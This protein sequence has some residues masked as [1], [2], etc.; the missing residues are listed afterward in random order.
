MRFVKTNGVN[1]ACADE[2]SGSPAF[3][4]VHGLAC[5]RTFWQPQ[6]DDLKRDHRCV[7][8]DLRG[9]GESPVAF[10]CDPETAAADVAGVIEVLDLGP[11]IIVGHSLGGVVALLLNYA[12]PELV[13]GVVAGDTPMG[14]ELGANMGRLAAAVRAEGS[15]KPIER[16]V[17]S[18][19][20]EST[21]EAVRDNVRKVMLG[22]PP[23][24][25]AGMLDGCA[26]LPAI[27]TDL[28][29]AADRKPFMA[30]W[31]ER[32]LGDPAWLRDT[33]MFLRQEPL[34]ATGHFFQLEEPAMTTALLRAFLDDVERDPRV[35]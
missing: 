21:P 4:F 20:V 22:C 27:S 11:S 30:I 32:P 31:A 7:A 35:V 10:P 33:T 19:F 15:T 8:V 2:G 12:R 6:F 24:V 16:L 3:F 23:D 5:D 34:A 14:A 28:V 13:L 1:L 17:E 18:F 26:R 9:R 29:K 25:L